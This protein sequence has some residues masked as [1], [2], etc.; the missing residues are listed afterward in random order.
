MN[1]KQ[2]LHTFLGFAFTDSACTE[3]IFFF[4]SALIDALYS[5]LLLFPGCCERQVTVRDRRRMIKFCREIIQSRK[6]IVRCSLGPPK[7]SL[8][9]N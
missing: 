2:G 5:I 1:I 6:S 8:K 7:T 4:G 3:I 9:N